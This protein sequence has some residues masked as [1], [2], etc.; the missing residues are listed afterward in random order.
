[1]SIRHGRRRR[2][3]SSNLLL[4]FHHMILEQ[5]CWTAQAVAVVN[6]KCVF[7]FFLFVCLFLCFKR[8]ACSIEAIYA[9]YYDYLCDLKKKNHYKKISKLH[10]WKERSIML[11]RNRKWFSST[12]FTWIF[13]RDVPSLRNMHRCI[14]SETKLIYTIL[15]ILLCKHHFFFLCSNDQNIYINYKKLC[16]KLKALAG[17]FL[18]TLKCDG[19]RI[20]INHYWGDLPS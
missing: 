13:F 18:Y 14:P 17:I 7:T 5:F 3:H 2:R 9:P 1:M 16:I 15:I 20:C 8:N 12:T 11:S 4:I 10:N 6:L 19:I